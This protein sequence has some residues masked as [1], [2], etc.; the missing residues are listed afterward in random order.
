LSVSS[1]RIVAGVFP[2]NRRRWWSR[3]AID[4]ATQL[5]RRQHT[6][7]DK[8]AR[9]FL[10]KDAIPSRP[11]ASPRPSRGPG[12]PPIADLLDVDVAKVGQLYPCLC[13]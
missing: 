2:E 12:A 3:P 1:E 5:E 11:Q 13:A 4:P 10:T 7:V 8:Q 6:P 9:M